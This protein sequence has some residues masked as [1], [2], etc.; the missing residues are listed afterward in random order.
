MTHKNN[1]EVT[2]A[3]IGGNFESK[4]VRTTFVWTHKKVSSKLPIRL[5]ERK[6]YLITTHSW[7]ETK[8]KWKTKRHTCSFLKSS[9]LPTE[10]G[11]KERR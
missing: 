4:L 10:N 7:R 8:E 3:Q 6:T 1:V 5:K 9:K 11:K 2:Q